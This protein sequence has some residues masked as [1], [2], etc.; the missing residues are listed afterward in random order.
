LLF[1]P[2]FLLEGV[3]LALAGWQHARTARG[4]RRWVAGISGGTL[5]LLLFGLMLALTGKRVAVG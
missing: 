1:E 4:R 2:W 3:L 5:V